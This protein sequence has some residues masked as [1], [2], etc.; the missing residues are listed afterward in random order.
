M[1]PYRFVS[2]AVLLLLTIAAAPP[3]QQAVTY[4]RYDVEIV[5][6]S[7]GSFWVTE[8]YTIRFDG[9]FQQGFA[10]IPLDS[11]DEIAD[12]QMWGDVTDDSYRQFDAGGDAPG[13]FRASSTADAVTVEWFFAPT[14]PGSTRI[15]HLRYRVVGGLWVYRD[16]VLLLWDAVPT[17]R[18][19]IPVEA[20]QVT[21][22]LPVPPDLSAATSEG[23]PAQWEI[24]DSTTF[25]VTASEALPQGTPLRVVVP[26][27]SDLLAVQ[28]PDWQRSSAPLD[29]RWLA[30]HVELTVQPGGQFL[31]REEQ[32]LQVV[33]GELY[34]GW[35]EIPWAYLDR[36]DNVQVWQ[37]DRSLTPSPQPQDYAYVVEE[38]PGLARWVWAD[39]FEVVVRPENR[40]TTLVEWAVP[41]VVAGE[42]TAF[43]LQYTVHGALRLLDEGQ[44]GMWSAVFAGRDLPVE[45]A[46]LRLRLPPGVDPATV[47]VEADAAT[48]E[49]EPDGTLLVRHSGSLA[50]DQDWVVRFALP[51]GATSAQRPAWQNE[52]EA[53]EAQATE[54]AWVQGGALVVAM[55]IFLGGLGC[56][57]LIWFVWGRDHPAALP[58]SYLS[59]P[60]SDLPP[61]IVA[62]LVD[63][64][65]GAK[66]VLADV[67]HLAA[68]GLISVDLRRGDPLVTLNWQEPI[69]PGAAVQLGDAPPLVL[70][71]HE[72]LLFNA[73]RQGLVNREYRQG[74]L[75]Q[76]IGAVRDNLPQVYEQMARQT[77]AFFSLRPS[78]A[79]QRWAWV[80]FAFAGLAVF[81]CLFS[82]CAASSYGAVM[83]A[84]AIS[85]LAVGAILMGVSRWMPQRTTKGAEEAQRWCAFRRYLENL[86][87]YGNLEAA[88]R[89]L[90]EEFAYAVALGVEKLVLQQ[91]ETLGAQAPTWLTPT[92]ISVGAAV[93][94]VARVSLQGAQGLRG[95]LITPNRLEEMLS[96]PAPHPH[97]RPA[98]GRSADLS[99]DGMSQQMGS[100]LDGASA[101]L[102]SL[103][104]AMA[105]DPH[106]GGGLLSTLGKIIEQEASGGGRG[107]HRPSSNGGWRSSSWSSSSRSS[108]SPSWRPSSSHRSSGFKSGFSSG[109]KSGGGGRRGFK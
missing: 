55:L 21:V 38:Q 41:A 99:L 91:A 23:A 83:V 62:Y 40:P 56:I 85:L 35:R 86:K 102:G 32:R 95:L 24:P 6:Q 67:L 29:Y 27:P 87:Q 68:L 93:A 43:T 17:D 76:V 42:T 59:E 66:G 3:Q 18:S 71:E 16:Q 45:Q 94:D 72:R 46:S 92:N 89:I 100:S 50:A 54:N 75:S 79:R 57:L 48:V 98:P 11:V 14:T 101:S 90:D 26:L 34:G 78:V 28:T 44:V 63:E 5:L 2:I 73:I 58:A 107:G 60:P 4:E 9:V 10:E 12:V 8:S 61:G 80:G 31:V 22:R 15:Y 97:L 108:R 103:L 30:Q 105:G 36:I 74:P 81:F 37:D 70:A 19:G 53:A 88:Q 51:A 47:I 64:E 104:D 25:V 39:G 77:S 49:V 109:R 96:Q 84:P 82:L 13:S 7:D 69:E 20:A 65:P 106:A 33:D 52:M 1:K